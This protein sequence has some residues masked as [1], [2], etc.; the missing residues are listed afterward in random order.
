MRPNRSIRSGFKPLA[1][2]MVF[3]LALSL[4]WTPAR[5]LPAFAQQ[6]GFPCTAC[7]VGA[8]GPQLAPTGRAFKI[9]GYTQTGGTG[10]GAHIPLA[11]MIIGSFT[12][13]GAA[14][15]TPP[16]AGFNTNNNPA[17][18]QRLPGRSRHR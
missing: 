7:H 10:L 12:H 15:P 6:T 14:Q 8:F 4:P 17:L 2:I 13:I 5:A 18:D 3:C 1:S 9:G 16:T 11:A